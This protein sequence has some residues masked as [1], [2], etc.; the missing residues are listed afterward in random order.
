[1]LPEQGVPAKENLSDLESYAC[2]AGARGRWWPPGTC[3][4]GGALPSPRAGCR[5]GLCLQL[6]GSPGSAGG[7]AGSPE[8]GCSQR[9]RKRASRQPCGRNQVIVSGFFLPSNTFTRGSRATGNTNLLEGTQFN[10]RAEKV[11]RP[12]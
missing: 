10:V 12:L 2:W 9:A 4:R 8:G 5:A 3:W 11:T 6:R 7:T 1:M